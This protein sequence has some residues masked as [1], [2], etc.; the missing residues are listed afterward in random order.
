MPQPSRT[1]SS[2]A[3]TG[4]KGIGAELFTVTYAVAI[5]GMTQGRA[6]ND[7]GQIVGNNGTA[8]VLS[9]PI[10]GIVPIAAGGGVWDIDRNGRTVVGQDTDGDPVIWSSCCTTGWAW[11]ATRRRSAPRHRA[12]DASDVVGDAVLITGARLA[13][14]HRWPGAQA[15]GGPDDGW[16]P[17]YLRFRSASSEDGVD[18]QPTRAGGGDGRLRVL[19]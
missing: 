8:I 16:Q 13:R 17:T 12:R 15:D 18:D 6:I 7:A 9:D 3:S 14:R 19:P 1:T 2:S 11:T 5:P 4:K 10:F